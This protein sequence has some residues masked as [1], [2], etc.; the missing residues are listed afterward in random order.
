MDLTNPSPTSWMWNF[1]GASTSSSTSQNPTGICYPTMGNY[2]V[3]LIVNNSNNCADTLTMSNYI[4]VDTSTGISSAIKSNGLEL[5]WSYPNPASDRTII[6]YS[7]DKSTHAQLTMYD[8]TGRL[9][10]D[11]GKVFEAAG[12]HKQLLKVS[13]LSSGK[14]FYMIRTD[15]AMLMSKFVIVR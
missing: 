5:K 7:L 10:Y 4:F 2:D 13:K 15:E 14:Y 8:A 9:V 11:S 6:C 1:A 12:E 3:T